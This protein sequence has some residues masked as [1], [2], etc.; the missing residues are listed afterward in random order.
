[1][2]DPSTGIHGYN[3]L[4][5]QCSTVQDVALSGATFWRIY[6]ELHKGE[7][8]GRAEEANTWTCVFGERKGLSLYRRRGR[9]ER[10]H[11]PPRGGGEYAV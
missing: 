3:D 2:L 1:M 8:G 7:R 5:H 11:M 10:T 6:V 9:G 4:V